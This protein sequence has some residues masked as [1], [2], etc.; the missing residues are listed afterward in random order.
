VK[1]PLLLSLLALLVAGCTSL[2]ETDPRPKLSG[3]YAE[4]VDPDLADVYEIV[5]KEEFDFFSDGRAIS[6]WILGKTTRDLLLKDLP[7][8]LPTPPVVSERRRGKTVY[9]IETTGTW[10]SEGRKIFYQDNG[11]PAE[12]PLIEFFLA[13][14]NPKAPR[15]SLSERHVFAID[16]NGDL[17]R[18]PPRGHP[19]YAGRFVKQK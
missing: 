16:S 8:H 3:R 17:L 19:Y 1:A 6:R 18:I 7:A 9:V 5:G 12:S 10:R 13:T 11:K 2:K 4:P 14:F 15:A